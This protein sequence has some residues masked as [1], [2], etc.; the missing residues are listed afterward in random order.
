MNGSWKYVTGALGFLLILG[1][2][3]WN[4]A[5]YY[6]TQLE[7]ARGERAQLREILQERKVYVDQ[8]PLLGKR[9]SDI[10]LKVG[11][12]EAAEPETAVMAHRL[13]VIEEWNKGHQARIDSILGLLRSMEER[14]MEC[15]GTRKRPEG[16]RN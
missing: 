14:V 13:A 10:E 5:T 7:A 4:A 16:G 3:L 2:T 11:K 9:L 8:L 1:T 15:E 12:I 6:S